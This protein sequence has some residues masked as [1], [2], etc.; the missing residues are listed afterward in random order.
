MELPVFLLSPVLAGG[1]RI[2]LTIPLEQGQWY[3]RRTVR[4]ECHRRL[5]TPLLGEE[6]DHRIELT[7]A[8]KAALLLAKQ[9]GV[10]DVRFES[11]RLTI[12]LPDP[13][14]EEVRREQ[15]HRLE[16]LFGVSLPEWPDG[17][18]LHV[19]ESFDPQRQAV[20]LVHGLEGSRSGLQR[21]GEACQAA[22]WQTLLFDYPNTGPI[23]WSGDRL[24]QKLREFSRQH[25]TTRIVVIAHSMGGLVVRH[26]LE[27]PW[28][29]PRSDLGCL[30]DVIF[31]G[32]PHQGSWL[33][34]ES[35]LLGLFN[36]P[37]LSRGAWVEDLRDG[38]GEARVDLMPQSAFLR[39]L[40]AHPHPPHVRYHVGIGTRSFLTTEQTAEIT[41]VVQQ[42]LTDP[43]LSPAL[44]TRWRQIVEAPELAPGQGDGAV[45]LTSARLPDAASERTFALNHL[46]LISLPGRKPEDSE[47]FQ[48]I[49]SVINHHAPSER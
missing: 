27:A 13:E 49:L 2:E 47:V 35:E 30:T 7:A 25:P 44:R 39:M 26:C 21:L 38:L 42:R 46:E 5:G 33:A 32:T 4:E 24:R 45:S 12:W 3:S 22:G 28:E 11:D 43:G 29:V 41:R 16:R 36:Q 20:L 10:L 9:A 18:G 1:G 14:D 31:L 23:A 19:P 8:E 15:R 17:K 40:N 48:W 34:G 6:E 37:V